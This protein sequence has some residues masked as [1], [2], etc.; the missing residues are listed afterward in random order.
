[1]VKI[2]D[3]PLAHNTERRYNIDIA[4]TITHLQRRNMRLYVVE[5]NAGSDGAD[6]PDKP[7]VSIESG[8]DCRKLIDIRCYLKANKINDVSIYVGL[9]SRHLLKKGGN[10]KSMENDGRYG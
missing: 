4:E 1:M 10:N 3:G 7:V 6:D 8:R 9:Q 2:D 5:V